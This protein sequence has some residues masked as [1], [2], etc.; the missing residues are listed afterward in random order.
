MNAIEKI[1]ETAKTHHCFLCMDADGGNKVTA[2]DHSP[3][4]Y[5]ACESHYRRDE[6]EFTSDY[7]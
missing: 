2:Y 6:W 3:Y 7:S 4:G 5:W 1:R